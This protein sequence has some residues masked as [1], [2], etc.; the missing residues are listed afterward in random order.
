MKSITP[1]SYSRRTI[2]KAG[3]GVTFA[4]AVGPFGT[5]LAD[6]QSTESAIGAWVKIN[7]DGDILIYGPAAEMGQ[8][9][10][11]ALP[12][13]LAE[14]MDA[15]WSS[16]RV[17]HS[18]IEPEIYG[19]EA[20]GGQSRMITVGS[21]S[22]R[23]Y[24]TKL[25]LAGAQIRRV[26]LDAVADEWNV[27]V[28]ELT[29]E[30]GTVVHSNSGKRISYGDIV[31]FLEAPSQM[32]DVDESQLKAPDDFGIIGVSVPR[33]DIPAKVDGSAEFSLDVQVPGMLYGMIARSPVHNGRPL[34][35]NEAEIRTMPG[36][37]STVEL[38]HGIGVIADTVESAFKAKAALQIE[39]AKG[40]QAENFDSDTS[41]AEYAAIPGSGQVPANSIFEKGNAAEGLQN[42]SNRYVA[43][44]LADHVY[45]AQMEPLNAVVSV[46]E[47]G[48]S[49]EA[50]IGTQATSGTRETIAE[51]LGIDFD[52][53][54]LHPCYLG[55][56]F[57]R[58]SDIDW[59]IEATQLAGAIR[60]PVKLIWSREDDLQY[61]KFR[62]MCLQRLE[63]GVDGDGNVTSWTHCVVGDGDG[64]IATGV[65]IPFYDIPNQ[66]ME[67]CSVSHGIRLKHWRAV[68]HGFNKFAIEAFVDEIASGQ[69]IDPYQFRRTLLRKSPR[70]V[71]VLDSVAEM[72]DWGGNV[73]EGRARGIAFAEHGG[74]LAAAV[75]EISVDESSG[76]IKV[77]KFWC[78]VDGGVVIQPNNAQA[79]IE[80]GIV[81]GLSSALF[82]RVSIKNGVVQQ[83]NF[84]DYRMMRMSETPEIEVRFIESNEP[85]A[86]MGE[87]GVP[88]TGGAVANAFAALTGKRLHHMP[89]TPDRVKS[90]LG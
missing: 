22:V 27:P 76:K 52:Q 36:V 55:G 46:S 28:S 45:H 18:P 51:T 85:P 84:H 25:R 87:I 67:R 1:A 34:S 77:H 8:G 47:K 12:V 20:W 50:W 23:G 38:D 6:A 33:Q 70:G 13:I 41:L 73:P 29:T 17:E 19:W 7:T 11:T 24:Y 57:G 81:T 39:W 9:S 58:R 35:F 69:S 14:E 88:V 16:V 44:Y 32:P 60:K 4:V 49:A 72:A 48:D 10:M 90:V 61:G 30:P 79:Q 63:A 64:L 78:A 53:V 21:R 31:V 42:A 3:A 74:S 56:G 26:L 89:F 68:G 43:D 59:T 83:S 2:L 71:K 37:V 54:T 75:A 62:P 40:T 65:E 86:G 82:E 80:G 66:N 15:N 5:A